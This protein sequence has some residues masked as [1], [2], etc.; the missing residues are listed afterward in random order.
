MLREFHAAE[1]ELVGRAVV[2]SDGK[3]GM[4]DGVDLDNVHGL[5]VSICGHHGQWPVSTIKYIQS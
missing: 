1:E 4:I 5:R 3:A 2:M